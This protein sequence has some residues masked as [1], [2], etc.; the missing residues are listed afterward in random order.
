MTDL[1]SGQVDA[2]IEHSDVGWVIKIQVSNLHSGSVQ[3]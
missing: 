2:L 1:L 3:S